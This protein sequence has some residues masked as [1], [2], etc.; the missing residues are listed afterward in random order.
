MLI[1]VCVDM[2]EAVKYCFIRYDLSLGHSVKVD[3]FSPMKEF[4]GCLSLDTSS[5]KFFPV[6][7]TKVKEPSNVFIQY[8]FLV[9]IVIYL[10]LH[11]VLRI[12]FIFKLF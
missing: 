8:C 11:C 9:V 2:V 4:F 3:S 12:S 1:G 7:L 5:S 6:V 10:F